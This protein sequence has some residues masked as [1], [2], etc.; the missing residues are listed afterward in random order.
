MNAPIT[1]IETFFNAPTE[2]QIDY[3][4]SHEVTAQY[5][6]QP[7]A[8]E[9]GMIHGYRPYIGIVPMMGLWPD[10]VTAVQKGIEMREQII[11]E[12]SNELKTEQQGVPA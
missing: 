7:N 9:R 8:Y 5:K 11:T 10:E 6:V 1:S 2:E 3:L 12:L 4:R